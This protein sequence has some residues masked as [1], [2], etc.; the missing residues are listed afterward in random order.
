[1]VLAA[2]SGTSLTTA[3]INGFNDGI[4]IGSEIQEAIESTAASIPS[5]VSATWLNWMIVRFLIILPTQYLLQLNSFVL[6]CLGLRVCAR[7]VRGGGMC[8]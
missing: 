7:A 2:F 5:L 3:V 4:Q 1:M 6:T 8:T